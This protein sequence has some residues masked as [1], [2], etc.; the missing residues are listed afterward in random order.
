M[1]ARWRKTRISELGSIVRGRGLTRADL[2]DHGVPCLRYGEIYTRYGDTT[3]T[4]HSFVS[5]LAARR[6]IPLRCGDIVF[7]SSGETRE[8]IGKALAWLGKDQAVVG[9]DTLILRE[10]GQDPTFLVHVLNS[11]SATRQKIRLGKGY[12]IVHIHAADLESILIAIPPVS[13]QRW[14][15]H[16]LASWDK[17]LSA[18]RALRAALE[19]QQRALLVRLLQA[20]D[21]DLVKEPW[22]RVRLGD[23]AE[24]ILSSVDKKKV[25]GEHVVKLC[26]YMDVY[27]ND[28]VSPSMTDL[29]KATATLAEI[30]RFA[31][32]AGDVVMTKDSEDPTDIAVS[33]LVEAGAPHFVCGY[34]LAILRPGPEVDGRFLKYWLDLPSS[35]AYFG[36]RAN[37]V[38][39]F[40]LTVDSVRDAVI[41]LPPLR[42]QRRIAAIIATWDHAIRRAIDETEA[43]NRQRRAVIAYAVGQRVGG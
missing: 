5:P 28:T 19:R 39:R 41:E 22:H 35:R 18:L 24:V 3:D 9:G 10:H 8:D 17:A 26:N 30:Q 29:M 37:G 16:L 12:A 20:P 36:S 31:L 13:T 33:A 21:P 38:T 11:A 1:P 15:T 7:A 34:H 14:A 23:V 40:G 4:L 2:T 27:N 42:K 25:D 32:V 6:A 43:V